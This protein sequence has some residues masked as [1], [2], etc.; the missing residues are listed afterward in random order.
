[1]ALGDTVLSDL[2]DRILAPMKKKKYD[3]QVPNYLGIG[4]VLIVFAWIFFGS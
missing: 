4:I 2:P 1:M 3:G